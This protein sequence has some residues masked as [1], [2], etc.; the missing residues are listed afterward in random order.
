MKLTRLKK[1]KTKEK[2]ETLFL[3]FTV[4]FFTICFQPFFKQNN[5]GVRPKI[6]ESA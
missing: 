5:S 4:V 6:K 1:K 2:E 3:F